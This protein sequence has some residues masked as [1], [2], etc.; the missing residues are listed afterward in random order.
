MDLSP[1]T[2]ISMQFNL[3]S[4]TKS[5]F[6]TVTNEE[7]LKCVGEKRNLINNIHR[8]QATFFGYVMRRQGM[9]NL[10]TT[11]WKDQRGKK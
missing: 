9:E 8:R 7:T 3:T 11:A 2:S 10:I 1:A 4:A 6:E 5:Y